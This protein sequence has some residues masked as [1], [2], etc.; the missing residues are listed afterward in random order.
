[1]RLV[2]QEQPRLDC[3]EV[4]RVE[5]NLNCRD[6]IIPI[7]RALQHLYEDE[8]LRRQLLALV[9]ANRQRIVEIGRAFVRH[10]ITPLNGCRSRHLYR[11]E[12]SVGW[13]HLGQ[14]DSA[15]LDGSHPLMAASLAFSPAKPGKPEPLGVALGEPLW[16]QNGSILRPLYARVPVSP[17]AISTMSCRSGKRIAPRCAVGKSSTMRCRFAGWQGCQ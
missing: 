1:V 3:P 16:S 10:C 5:L 17:T 15:Q 7:L 14:G 6:E 8:P 13:T 2:Y 12:V 4:G 9:G 11:G